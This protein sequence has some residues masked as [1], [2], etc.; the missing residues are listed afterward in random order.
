MMKNKNEITTQNQWEKLK[1]HALTLVVGVLGEL[2]FPGA[3]IASAFLSSEITQRSFKRRVEEAHYQIR[4]ELENLDLTQ[5]NIAEK[6]V[7][8]FVK[9]GFENNQRKRENFAKLLKHYLRE[10]AKPLPSNP[11]FL[12][13]TFNT[14]TQQLS[15]YSFEHLAFLNEFIKKHKITEISAEIEK[16]STD[17]EAFNHL[18]QLGNELD[19]LWMT[20]FEKRKVIQEGQYPNRAIQEL[21]NQGLIEE[22]IVKGTIV[23]A[24]KNKKCRLTELGTKYLEWIEDTVDVTPSPYE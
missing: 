23:R 17:P 2:S 13:D 20:Y 24:E 10:K 9:I 11:D 7:A 3:G 18:H 16:C 4:P 6:V 22:A 15:P 5:N 19:S 21:I 8:Q 14:V 1:D 12:Y